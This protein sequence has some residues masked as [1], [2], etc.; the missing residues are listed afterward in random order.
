MYL[1]VTW[2]E[3]GVYYYWM[4]CPSMNVQ[5]LFHNTSRIPLHEL[6]RI[7]CQSSLSTFLLL[8]GMQWIE[9]HLL[10]Y[11]SADYLP[12]HLPFLNRQSWDWTAQVHLHLWLITVCKWMFNYIQSLSPSIS[13]RLSKCCLQVHSHTGLITTTKWIFNIYPFTTSR[14][15]LMAIFKGISK[16]A[17]SWILYHYVIHV[18]FHHYYI[19]AIKCISN[20]HKLDVLNCV[21]STTCTVHLNVYS[22]ISFKCISKFTQ[23]QPP[24]HFQSSF[25]HSFQYMSQFTQSLFPCLYNYYIAGYRNYV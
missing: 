14:F 9:Y 24:W 5:L 2:Q 17:V 4:Q 21:Q 1:S 16:P 23:L 11:S 10:W 25:T 8:N 15:V 6:F 22:I 19:T 12:L 18:F 3:M 7:L 13:I 20:I